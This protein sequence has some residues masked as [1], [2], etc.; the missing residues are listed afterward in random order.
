[1]RQ[2]WQHRWSGRS[3]L[4][5]GGQDP[6]F[7]PAAMVALQRQVRGSPAPWVLPEGGHFL[8]E[9]GAALARQAVKYFS[10]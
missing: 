4:V 9:H 6:V 1:M 7:G 3:L 5:T 8:P 2:F 10:P